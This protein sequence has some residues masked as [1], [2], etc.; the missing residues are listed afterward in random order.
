[1]SKNEFENQI[2]HTPY[3]KI[4]QNY[5]IGEI[6][7]GLEGR[8]RYQISDHNGEIFAEAKEKSNGIA[9]WVYR[10]FFKYWRSFEI[11]IIDMRGQLQL[12]LK[13]PFRFFLKSM[14]VTYGD[15][16]TIGHIQQ[17]FAILQK[18]FDIFD[19]R[20]RRVATIRSPFF[21]MWTFEI[22]S[23]GR[24][25]GEIQKKWNGAVSELFTDK[26][27]FM[28]HFSDKNLSPQ[29]RALFLATSLLIDV[30]YFENNYSG[31]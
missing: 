22:K 24:P 5:E 18:K 8:N 28:I 6:L 2:S 30:V 20:N 19:L 26:D 1:M 21:K 16:K 27:N 7:I 29:D 13:C 14:F 25:V 10:Q 23:R 31:R 4:Q 9:S 15:G 12:K 3:L 11:E 17:R